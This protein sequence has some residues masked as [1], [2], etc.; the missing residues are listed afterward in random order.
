MCNAEIHV[1]EMQSIYIYIYIYDQGPQN[2]S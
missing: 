2:Q 1:D